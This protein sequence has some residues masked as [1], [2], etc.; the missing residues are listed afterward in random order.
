MTKQLWTFRVSGGESFKVQ[1]K[2]SPIMTYDGMP[3]ALLKTLCTREQAMALEAEMRT[4][5]CDVEAMC[6]QETQ[7]QKAKRQNIMHVLGGE[8]TFPCVECPGCAWFDPEIDSL[9]GAGFSPMGSKK[10]WED[11]VVEGAMTN[12]KYAA[13]FTSCPLRE[14]NLQ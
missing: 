13:D 1:V 2:G 10:G 3:N 12:E 7:E 11:P 9:C 5:G 6:P 8:R 14:G 4:Y